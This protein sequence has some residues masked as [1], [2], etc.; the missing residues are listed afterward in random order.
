MFQNRQG[1]M[2]V[3]ISIPNSLYARMMATI[4]QRQRSKVIA[5]LLE[6]EIK[7]REQ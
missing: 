1:L 7:K 4:P 3:M 2:K 5:E 6:G